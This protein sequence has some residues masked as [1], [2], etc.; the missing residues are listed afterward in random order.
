[1]LCCIFTK[2]PRSLCACDCCTCVNN[3]YLSTESLHWM[4]CVRLCMWTNDTLM[5]LWTVSIGHD[6]HHIV[7]WLVLEA[8]LGK[9]CVNWVLIVMSIQYPVISC[10]YNV[11]LN[12]VVLCIYLW[13]MI[14]RA[15]GI[16]RCDIWILHT[17]GL[18]FSTLVTWRRPEL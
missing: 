2:S 16:L 3:N 18:T 6:S 17:V 1:M 7:C 5:C 13:N 14:C 4:L 15:V 8:L 10:S 9:Q 12:N 11:V